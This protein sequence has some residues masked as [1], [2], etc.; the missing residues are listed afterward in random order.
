MARLPQPGGDNGDWGNILNDYLSQTHKPDGTIKD[1]AVTNS[2]IAPDAITATEIAN[3]SIQEAQLASDVQTKLNQAAPTWTTLGGKPSVIAAG[4]DT[5]AARDS[6]DAQRISMVDVRDFGAVCDGVTDD[7]AAWAAAV[8][9]VAATW[10]GMAGGAITWRGISSVTQIELLSRVSIIGQ[11]TEI[12]R[13]TQRAGRAA[14]QH[15]ILLDAADAQDV[16]LMHFTVNGNAVNQ[17]GDADGIYLDNTGGSN[18]NR[19]RHLISDVCIRNVKGNG[20][21]WGYAMRTSTIDGL[22]VYYCD[23]YG[24]VL[25]TFSDNTM[26]NVDVGQSGLDGILMSNGSSNSK[27]ANIKSWY[28]GRLDGVGSGLRQTGGVTNMFTNISTQENMGHGFALQGSGDGIIGQTMHSLNSDSDNRGAVPSSAGMTLNNVQHSLIDISITSKAPAATKPSSGLNISANCVGNK[29]TIKA[30][31]DGIA[32]WPSNGSGWSTNDIDLGRSITTVSPTGNF[33]PQVFRYREAHLTLTVNLTINNPNT[34]SGG[35]PVG[36][37]YQFTFI[38]DGT[39]GRAVTWS[40]AYKLP[41]SAVF[42]TTAGTYS[43]VEFQCA[44]EGNWKMIHF[45]TNIPA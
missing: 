34:P 39:G 13:I 25:S 36:M 2:A 9:A 33:S 17:V 43:M 35:A 27:F 32:S 31:P 40:S 24:I 38:Q 37:R 7:T 11:G 10:E 20:L 45:M 14:G 4:S 29:L 30:D 6:I 23:G 42:S 44:G 28:S 21:Y 26:Q 15:C 8:A 22:S 1:N 16:K 19:A 12:S 41:A 5:V 18:G 3:S